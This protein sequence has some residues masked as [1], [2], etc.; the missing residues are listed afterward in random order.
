MPYRRRLLRGSH[1]TRMNSS[2]GLASPLAIIWAFEVA[3]STMSPAAAGEAKQA[4]ERDAGIEAAA[5]D[6][7]RGAVAIVESGSPPTRRQQRLFEEAAQRFQ[8]RLNKLTAAQ[9]APPRSLCGR[10]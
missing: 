9:R 5:H 4:L 2:L 3:V 6:L 7:Y 8:E 1:P 10:E